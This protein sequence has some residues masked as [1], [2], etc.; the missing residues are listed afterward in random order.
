MKGA[1]MP[2][3]DLKIAGPSQAPVVKQLVEQ[4]VALTT[5]V[6]GK[7]KD[8]TTVSV[9]RVPADLWF[10][11]GRPLAPGRTGIYLQVNVTEGTNSKDEKAAFL[12]GAFAAAESLLGPVD[13]A[14][15]ILVHGVPADAYGYGGVTQ[16][17]RYA[18]APAQ[19]RAAGMHAS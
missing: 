19:L 16:E 8:V 11:A 4:L 6:L 13:P 1:D 3:L 12:K 14:S 2:S 10:V 17:R 15:Y 18:T 7:H 9:Q 5:E